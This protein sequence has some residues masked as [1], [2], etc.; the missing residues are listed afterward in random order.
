MVLFISIE[1]I[2][3]SA[4]ITFTPTK[5]VP[6][7][8]HKYV[9]AKFVVEGPRRIR[10]FVFVFWCVCV[11]VG[12]AGGGWGGSK[13][14]YV[15]KASQ[16]CH[17]ET[18]SDRWVSRQWKKVFHAVAL[19]RMDAQLLWANASTQQE[20]KLW[21][22]I[23]STLSWSVADSEQTRLWDYSVLK[24]YSS[25]LDANTQYHIFPFWLLREAWNCRFCILLSFLSVFLQVQLGEGTWG[26]RLHL[27]HYCACMTIQGI[28]CREELFWGWSSNWE[29]RA[30]NC[31]SE[32]LKR[33]LCWGSGN[34]SDTKCFPA[35]SLHRWQQREHFSDD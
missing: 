5:H 9:C 30:W 34:A 21:K 13:N 18:L 32:M 3:H 2:L 7:L 25:Q 33:L 12:G 23:E 17:S 24:H 1:L 16:L 31:P 29:K 4:V 28:L 19:K 27:Y 11:C 22:L 10:F 15:M 8:L 6:H 20:H 14:K 35:L 26:L